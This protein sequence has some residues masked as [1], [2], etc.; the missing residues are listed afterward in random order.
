MSTQRIINENNL[1]TSDIFYQVLTKTSV[2]LLK[3]LKFEVG[4]VCINKMR[5]ILRMERIH[6]SDFCYTNEGQQR[7]IRENLIRTA[8]N[9]I[10]ALQ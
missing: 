4:H 10:D 3:E 9:K 7:R 6:C 2:D 5:N 8:I 1:P